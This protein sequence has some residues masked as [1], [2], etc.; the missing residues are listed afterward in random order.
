MLWFE[1]EQAIY[2]LAQPAMPWLA[3]VRY[4]D[5]GHRTGQEY[6]SA[7]PIR[8]TWGLWWMKGLVVPPSTPADLAAALLR[9]PP[10]DP[11]SWAVA[12][13]I[14]PMAQIVIK[15][16]A[17]RVEAPGPILP[18][19]TR[20]TAGMFMPDGCDGFDA[21]LLTVAS[22]PWSGTLVDTRIGRAGE[23]YVIARLGIMPPEQPLASDP[24]AAAALLERLRQVERDTVM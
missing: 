7:W 3:E 9:Q 16:G 20:F 24:T 21:Q 23:P 22:G 6:V 10:K 11:A 19:G 8:M 18:A 4:C 13:M 1:N 17:P 14:D 2:A 5:L 12:S 15:R